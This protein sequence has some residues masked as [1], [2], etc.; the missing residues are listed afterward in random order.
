MK[1]WPSRGG[2]RATRPSLPAFS[3]GAWARGVRRGRASSSFRRRAGR[4]EPSTP[5]M[6]SA[7]SHSAR[8]KR[9]SRASTSSG[10]P[11]SPSLWSAS[12]APYERPVGALMGLGLGGGGGAAGS[13]PSVA[14][15]SAAVRRKAPAD[16]RNSSASHGGVRGNSSKATEPAKGDVSP[17]NRGPLLDIAAAATASRRKAQGSPVLSATTPPPACDAANAAAASNSTNNRKTCGRREAA[18]ALS[19]K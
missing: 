10:G 13:T 6:A 2:T 7:T 18:P 8:T 1:T 15:A 5:R 12:W 14:S 4:D 11:C 16:L 17:V 19:S 3:N 9:I